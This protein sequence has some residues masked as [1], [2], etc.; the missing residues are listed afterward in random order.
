VQNGTVITFTTTI[1]RIEP[2]EARTNNGQVRVKFIAGAQSGTATITAFSGGA[3]A[4]LENLKVGAAAVERVVVTANPNTLPANGGSTTVSARVEDVTGFGLSGLPVTFTTTQGSFS[5]NP[6]VTDQNGIATTTLT[7]TREAS[8]NASVSGK[9]AAAALVIPLAPRTGVTIS[10]PT[11]QVSAGLPVTFTVGVAATANIREVTI[12]FG[13]GF[14]SSLGAL[15]AS[16]PVQHVYTEAGT[17][18]ATATATEASGSQESVS[19]FVTVLPAQPP[20]V[21]VTAS[22]TNPS[23]GETVIFTATVQ[24]AI[25]TIVGYE[26]NFGTAATPPSTTSTGNRAQAFY[27]TTGT[28]LITVRVTQSTG[29]IGEG[30]ASIVVRP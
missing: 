4:K 28:K 6:A 19:T 29:P 21:I 1:G 10:G 23:V 15:S 11:T 9:S 16:T 8:I 27:N 26:W 25:G 20:S 22:N 7:T 5:V 18:R 14:R 24:G 3:S 2:S 12:D 17:F 30:T 13:D